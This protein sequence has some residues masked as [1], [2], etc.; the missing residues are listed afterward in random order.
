MNPPSATATRGRALLRPWLLALLLLA[1]QLVP[2]QVL[3]V[4]PAWNGRF[5]TGRPTEIAVTLTSPIGGIGEIRITG[6]RFRLEHQAGLEANRPWQAVLPVSPGADG[7]LAVDV[8]LPDG[9][10]LAK[11][12]ALRPED[13]RFAVRVAVPGGSGVDAAGNRGGGRT[14]DGAL[15]LVLA[16]GPDL[17]PRS[18]AGYQPVAGLTLSAGALAALDPAQIG[19]LTAYLTACGPL[20]LAE[21]SAHQL[22]RM[23][24]ASGCGGRFVRAAGAPPDA[25]PDPA[26]G[27]SEDPEVLALLAAQVGTDPGARIALLLLPYPILLAALAANRR[28]GPWLLPIPAAC[29][30]AYAWILPPAVT[31]AAA[32][33]WAEMDAGDAAY[34]FVR[35][36]ELRGGGRPAMPLHLPEGSGILL[37]A[38]A[39]PL[40]QRLLGPEGPVE[41]PFPPTLLEHRRYL[42]E[43]TAPAPLSLHMEPVGRGV[44]LV[45]RGSGEIPGGWLGWRAE[46]Y[47]VPALAAGASHTVEQEGRGVARPPVPRSLLAGGDPALL[48]PLP[49]WDALDRQVTGWLRIRARRDGA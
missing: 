17:L 44:R 10:R 12:L 15:A 38:D 31:G 20:V 40:E 4:E 22:E 43:G 18:A 11:A 19:A 47:A 26:L 42:L 25:R 33:T 41:L 23:K 39:G 34:R 37:A 49:G 16:V 32:A 36:L 27:L 21:V 3:E 2:A 1:P 9:S 45:N 28:V 30:L 5:A 24:A 14:G 48:V 8:A 35:L 13:G 6:S 7:R 29:A 46:V